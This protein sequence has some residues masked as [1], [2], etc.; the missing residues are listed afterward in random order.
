MPSGGAKPNA[1]LRLLTCDER[2]AIAADGLERRGAHHDVSATCAGF[3]CRPVP[4]PV[5]E[6]VEDRALGILLSPAPEHGRDV[7]MMLQKGNRRDGPFAS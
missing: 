7:G 1:K 2:F 3:A 6:C 4:L 5:A